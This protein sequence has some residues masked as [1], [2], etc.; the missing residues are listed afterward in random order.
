ML[1][2]IDA[3]SAW[4]SGSATFL[5]FLV[6]AASARRPD[7][8]WVLVSGP[9]TRVRVSEATV[10]VRQLRWTGS[11][12]L[13]VMAESFLLPSVAKRLGANAIVY[14]ADVG[15]LVG[16]V[17]PSIV[18]VRNPYVI[19]AGDIRGPTP[20]SIRVRAQLQ[21]TLLRHA[22]Q[23]ARLVVTFTETMREPTRRTLGLSAE[24]VRILRPGSDHLDGAAPLE[25]AR[26]YIL[27]VAIPYPHKNLG[28]LLEAWRLLKGDGF[29]YELVVVGASP[30]ELQAHV[31]TPLDA[32]EVVGTGRLP[33]D[34]VAR[35]YRSAQA[36]VLPT[37]LESYGHPLVEALAAGVPSACSDLPVL[38]EVS[39]ETAVFFDP[40]RPDA[41]ARAIREVSQRRRPKDRRFTLRPWS[42]CG[43]DFCAMLEEVVQ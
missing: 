6:P 39:Q 18:F 42:R 26:P 21:R 40:S 29:P 38:H 3:L 30:G 43:E 31:R 34:E 10:Q 2:V 20:W 36:F 13:R 41:I 14:P 33:L 19:P 28:R 16:G 4:G 32:L 24:K 9:Q 5:R 25:R 37:L 11:L 15:P 17:V 27:T 23:R 8:R 35:Y 1:V 12:S 22:A 7:W